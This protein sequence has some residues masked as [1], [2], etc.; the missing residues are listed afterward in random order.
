MKPLW[1]H[2]KQRPFVR[3]NISTPMDVK[4]YG[5]RAEMSLHYACMKDFCTSGASALLSGIN[6]HRT[7]IF[8]AMTIVITILISV[9]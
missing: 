4:G 2:K 6:S 7:L 9:I 1:M 5:G 8:S 3:L